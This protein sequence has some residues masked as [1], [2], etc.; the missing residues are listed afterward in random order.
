LPSSAGGAT[1]ELFTSRWANKE[2]AELQCQPVGIS[3]G[4]PRFKTGFR[5]KLARE[6]APDDEAWA[7]AEDKEAFRAS[8]IRQLEELGLDA[9]LR[10]L[11]GISHEHRGL[12]LVLICYEPA[13]EFCHRHVLSAWLRERGVEIRELQPG[14]LPQRPEAPQRLF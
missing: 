11:S 13:E 10:R 9:I 1:V 2:L 4:T 14:D 8:Y 5:Y 6:L 3:R 12:P 7:A